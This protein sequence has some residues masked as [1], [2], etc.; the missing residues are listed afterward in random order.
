M[1]LLLLLG[2]PVGEPW[3][4]VTIFLLFSNKILKIL[5][6]IKLCDYANFHNL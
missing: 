2:Y 6:A 1:G 5:L 4:T 3:V